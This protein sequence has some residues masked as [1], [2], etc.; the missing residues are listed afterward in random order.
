MKAAFSPLEFNRMLKP[1]FQPESRRA[2]PK[3]LPDRIWC[4][5]IAFDR[6]NCAARKRVR[7]LTRC[8]DGPGS[9]A[10]AAESV[11]C[12]R[13]RGGWAS[14]SPV[15]ENPRSCVPWGAPCVIELNLHA[16]ATTT[17]KVR[18]TSSAASMTLVIQR[19]EHRDT[20]A[21]HAKLD[22]LLQADSAAN[23]KVMRIDDKDAEEVERAG[24][25]SLVATVQIVDA[26]VE[27]SRER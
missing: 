14:G 1:G 24:S 22:E 17:P 21:I 9:S 18:P 7:L 4:R 13:R 6:L 27:I 12:H 10:T 11:I 8:Y 26:S 15:G 19:A 23:N 5:E 16:N 25:Q 2:E 20:E 3:F